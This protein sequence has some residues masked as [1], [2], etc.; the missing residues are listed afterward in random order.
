VIPLASMFVSLFGMLFWGLT[1]VIES[2]ERA[3]LASKEKP[4]GPQ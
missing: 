3:Q 4:Y 1:L 2:L